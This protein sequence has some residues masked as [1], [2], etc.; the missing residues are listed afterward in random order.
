MEVEGGYEAEETDVM[1]CQNPFQE[2]SREDER[3]RRANEY[4]GP[5]QLGLSGKHKSQIK[6]I[7][8]DI[9][10]LKGK[11]AL[12]ME[13][14]KVGWANDNKNSN[15][16]GQSFS[17]NRSVEKNTGPKSIGK[18]GKKTQVHGT[19]IG[20][21]YFVELPS[22]DDDDDKTRTSKEE[23][24]PEALEIKLVHGINQKLKIKRK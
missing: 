5:N 11:K 1:S 12:E 13:V 6:Q 16:I 2:R 18:K 14:M 4:I 15:I 3:E 10:I 17:L 8:L 22:D 23:K 24:I 9:E 7:E 21:Y 20:E 19:E